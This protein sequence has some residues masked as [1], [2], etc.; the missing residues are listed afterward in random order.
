MTGVDKIG[1]FKPF[2]ALSRAE[3]AAVCRARRGRRF[4]EKRRLP[5]ALTGA[6][7]F[8]KCAPAVFYLERYDS[9][10]ILIGIGSGFFISR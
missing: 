4:P 1:T 2:D 5:L 10:G 9:E 8:K 6:D 3:A 7:I